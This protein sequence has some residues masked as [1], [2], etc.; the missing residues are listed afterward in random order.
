MAILSATA[1]VNVV[2]KIVASTTQHLL[3]GRAKLPMSQAQANPVL[4]SESMDHWKRD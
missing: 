2:S 3:P 1:V 4:P